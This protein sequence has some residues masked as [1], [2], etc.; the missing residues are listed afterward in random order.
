METT[1]VREELNAMGLC[2]VRVELS[3]EDAS[4]AL[5]TAL[6][7]GIAKTLCERLRARGIEASAA[8]DCDDRSMAWVHL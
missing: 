4:R 5:D 8:I 2:D 3:R 7:I 6:P 1:I